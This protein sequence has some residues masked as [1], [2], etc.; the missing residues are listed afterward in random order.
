M[1][2]WLSGRVSGWVAGGTERQYGRMSVRVG[3]WVS[4]YA[5]DWIGE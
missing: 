2:V 5:S 3:E 4:V 1:T